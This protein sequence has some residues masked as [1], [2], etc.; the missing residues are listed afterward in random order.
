MTTYKVSFDGFSFIV[1]LTES[2]KVALAQDEEI[3]IT[4]VMA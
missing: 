4:E 3:T 2:E 1:E